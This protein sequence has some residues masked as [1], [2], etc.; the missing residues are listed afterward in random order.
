MLFDI[1]CLLGVYVQV[2]C[3]CFVF[4]WFVVDVLFMRLFVYVF[5][6]LTVYCGLCAC[7]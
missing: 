3:V 4:D 1:W 2:A 7:L 5:K 6:C